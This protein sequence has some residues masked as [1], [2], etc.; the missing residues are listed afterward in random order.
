MLQDDYFVNKEEQY[1]IFES[2]KANN[3]FLEVVEDGK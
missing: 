1:D 2:K 3:Y